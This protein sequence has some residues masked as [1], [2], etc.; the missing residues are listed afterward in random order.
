MLD[1]LKKLEKGL[2]IYAEFINYLVVD[3]TQ[4]YKKSCKTFFFFKLSKII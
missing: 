3:K 2:I 4:N 1:I